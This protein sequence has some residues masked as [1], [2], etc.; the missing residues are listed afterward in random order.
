MVNTR[1]QSAEL[2][3]QQESTSTGPGEV[4]E[5]PK[6]QFGTATF[7]GI[8]GTPQAEQG[9]PEAN[10]AMLAMVK[11]LVRERLANQQPPAP[12]HIPHVQTMRGNKP[13]PYHGKS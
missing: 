13:Q 4:L 12:Q 1:M 8:Q 11:R 2:N 5:V 3:S 6:S 10:K 7:Q 9:P